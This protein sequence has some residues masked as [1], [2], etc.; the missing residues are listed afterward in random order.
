MLRFTV[1]LALLALS[2]PAVAG[3]GAEIAYSVGRD[4]FLINSDGSG[5]RLLYR[6]ATNTSIFAISMKKNGSELSFEE[7]SS[8]GQT[9]RLITVAYG[10]SGAAQV[11]R[12]VPGC[13][14]DVDT[15]SD[16]ALLTVEL[17]CGGVVKF[18]AP[19]SSDLQP[20]GVPRQASK[21]AWMPDGSFLYASQGKIWHATLSNPSGTAIA[22]QDCVQSI[23]TANFASEALVAVG[24][25]CD[26]P[27][28]DR[29]MVPAGTASH[30]AA[31][32]DAAYS[33]DD[34][35]YVFV[36]PPQR[37]GTFLHIA[38]IDGVGSSVQIG[39]SGNYASVDWRGDSQP[40]TCSLLTN[41]ALE[42]REV[43]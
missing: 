17:N 5:K 37:R 31:G 12:N 3:T 27:R 15:R 25:F 38:R 1:P 35:C 10:N 7:V 21:V 30:I 20:V 11:I 42:F 8:K 2:A 6:G 24:Q 14:F 32:P 9:G 33:Q 41:D 40:G 28:I 36:A 18:A 29:M 34:K 16:G 23:N 22:N 26:G 13:R 19:G 39:N 43:K 4:V